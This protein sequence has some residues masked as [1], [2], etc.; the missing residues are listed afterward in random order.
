VNSISSNQPAAPR[1]V[2]GLVQINNSF[3]DACYL[4]YSVGLLQAYFSKNSPLAAEVGFLPALYRRIPLEDALSQLEQADIIG[5]SVYS[6]NLNYSLE[7]ARLL[8]T[9]RP[10]RLVILGGPQIPDQAE[11]F[12]RN[13]ASVDLVCHGEGE[14]AFTRILEGALGE[15][16]QDTGSISF[17]EDDCFRNNPGEIRVKDLSSLPSPYLEGVFDELVARETGHQ[18]LALWETNRGCPYSCS[19]CDWGAATKTDLFCFDLERLEAELAWFADSKIEFVFCCDSNFG[20]LPRDLEISRLAA[21]SSRERGY[22]KALSVQNTKNN[23][24]RSYEIQKILSAAGL[25][26]G[27]NLALQSVNPDTLK[28]VGRQ[29]IPVS[30]FQEL[31]TRFSRDAVE[32]FTDIILGLPGESYDSFASG[33]DSII[34]QGQHHRIQFINL[35]ILPNAPM[36]HPDYRRAHGLETVATK[37]VNNHGTLAGSGD[38]VDETQELV[39]ATSTLPREAWARAR[40]FSWMASLLYF[41]KL[42]QIPLQVL[43]ESCALGYRELFELFMEC[44]G[45]DYPVLSEICG[46]FSS[47]AESIQAGGSE[48]TYSQEWLGIHWP[49]D[50]YQF[51]RLTLEGKLGAFYAEAELLLGRELA[52]RGLEGS[53]ELLSD[54]V[55]LNRALVK[56]PGLKHELKVAVN[57][58]VWEIYRGALTGAR[59]PLE[60]GRRSYLVRRDRERWSG[61]ESWLTEVVW[62]GNKK[63]AYMYTVSECDRDEIPAPLDQEVAA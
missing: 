22:P 38:G 3:S 27:V 48:F 41:D 1:R 7:L 23:A 26:K 2:V 49:H 35:T 55:R 63:G 52:R 53:R 59:A 24:E 62:Y 46:F 5:I 58:N 29:N 40:V 28:K 4:P 30:V 43:H 19:Y 34:E 11:E 60:T 13:N 51:I 50:E 42:L 25:S 36:A 18:W 17:L 37:L 16:W 10:E 14:R 45:P 44:S 21:R 33:I 12:L 57:H 47:E 56:E 6:W 15:G 31:Q 9:E 61:V 32:T 8:K 39:I 20:L 54:A